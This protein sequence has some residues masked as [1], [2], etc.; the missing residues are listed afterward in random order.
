MLDIIMTIVGTLLYPL[1]SII[2]ILIDVLQ[3]MFNS[4]AG[5]GSV[6]VPSTAENTWGYGGPVTNVNNGEINGTGLIF[7]FL[8]TDLVKN[9]LM[10]IMLL[11]VFLLIVFTIMAFIKNAYTVK[12]KTWQEIIGNA[13]KGLLSF[14]AIPVFCLLGVW[15]SNIVLQAIN[16]ATSS[17][18]AT[19]MS[20][21]LFICAAYNANYYR[22]DSN[23]KDKTTAENVITVAK[24][25]LT[26]INIEIPENATND[27]LAAIVDQVYAQGNNMI[28]SQVI[29]AMGY[30]LAAINYLIIVVGGIFM[31]YVLVTLAYAMIRRM[32]MLIM[33]FVISPAICAMYPLDDGSAVGQWRKQFISLT[34]GAYG[35]VAAMNIFFS[36]L[37][38][39]QD[40]SFLPSTMVGTNDVDYIIQILIM[41]CGL[42]VVKEMMSMLS[43]MIGGDDAYSKG[44]SLRASTTKAVRQYGNKAIGGAFTMMKAADKGWNEIGKNGKKK[45]FWGGVG[46]FLGSGMGYIGDALGGM[47]GGRKG[48]QET[49]KTAKDMQGE[50]EKEA[51]TKEIYAELKEIID[52]LKRAGTDGKTSKAFAH[53]GKG[54]NIEDVLKMADKYGL[55]DQAASLAGVNLDRL[56]EMKEAMKPVNEAAKAYLDVAQE[57][58]ALASD[59]SKI[60]DPSSSLFGKS[61]AEIAKMSPTEAKDDGERQLIA[62]SKRLMRQE[63]TARSQYEKAKGDADKFVTSG[64]TELATLIT[65]VNS[66]MSDAISAFDD[67]SK[68]ATDKFIDME[69]RAASVAAKSGGGSQKYNNQY[70]VEV[71][72]TE[73]DNTTA[74]VNS[75][76]DKVVDT[77][78][79][80][81]KNDIERSKTRLVNDATGGSGGKGK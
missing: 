52:D 54:A 49:V 80:M 24:G 44:A 7:F 62:E 47:V 67:G 34:I 18:G 22:M 31:L 16:G 20:N 58:R 65:S 21:K 57:L 27:Q 46:G 42:F 77:L 79:H 26:D 78:Q 11:A 56:N 41:T 2:F 14:F 3:W 37:P 4:L 12:P 81:L 43:S 68:G 45:G 9:L 63:H 33:L 75:Q 25:H 59:L 72:K 69:E 71:K 50:K 13:L 17:G 23:K 32:F 30:Q 39:V 1:F 55:K 60:T 61:I 73:S 48:L 6:L 38:L 19:Q 53:I 74:I 76:L 35:A 64:D 5:I 36:L 29:V 10:S 70:G 28:Y 51:K 66:S 15:V 8:N 40:I